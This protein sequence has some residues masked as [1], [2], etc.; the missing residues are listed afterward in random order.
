MIGYGIS[1]FASTILDSGSTGAPPVNTVAPVISGTQVVGSALSSTTGT[2]TGSPSPTFTYQWY[3]GATLITGATSSSYTLVQA[4]AGNTSNITCKVTGTNSSGSSTSTSNILAQILDSDTNTFL[5]TASI[6]DATI[7]SATNKFVLDVKGYSL[8][9]KVKAIFP[10]V[11][12]TSSTHSY[13]LKNPSQ[14]Q[15]TW[16]GG[17]THSSNGVLFGGVN[18]YGNTNFASNSF[19][20]ANNFGVSS[21]VRN[22]NDAGGDI[23]VFAPDLRYVSS[24]LSGYSYFGIG[25]TYMAQATTNSQGFWNVNRTSA[26]VVKA[27]KNGSSY[28]TGTTGAG[29][30]STQNLFVGALNQSGSANFY[31]GKQ[32]ALDAIHDGFTDAEAANWYTAVQAFQTALSR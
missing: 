19:T 18:G 26:S 32:H 4:D 12:G 24:R 27:F 1:F 3:R 31:T 6:T 28:I 22:N 20:S 15:I 8:W 13:N 30:L 25:N 16:S 29:T 10:Y 2:W 23:G 9:T 21:Y 17:I 14:Y 5:T 7:K 11:G